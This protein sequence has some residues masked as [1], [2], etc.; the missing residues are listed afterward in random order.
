MKKYNW[1]ILGCGKIAKKFASDLKLLSNANLYA[2]ASRSLQKAQ[3]FA[4]TFGFEK[5]YGGYEEMLK[6]TELDVVYIA[7]PHTFHA[8]HSLLSINHGKAVLCEKA[9]AI[10]EKEVIQM[11]TASN[12][13]KIFLMEA[14]WTRF[15]PS[16]QKV[17]EIIKTNELGDLK[18]I[19][20]DF[21]F[22][23]PFN[24]ESR[25]YNLDLGGGSLLDIGIYPVFTALMA[26]GVPDE[27]A[28]KAKLSKTGSDEYLEMVFSYTNG[29]KAYL[30]SGFTCDSFNETIFHFE[31]GVI[32]ISRELNAPIT[33]KKNKEVNELIVDDGVGFGYQFE[34]NHVMDCLDKGLT[35]S[36][37]LPHTFSLQLMQILD[38]VRSKIGVVY[39]NHD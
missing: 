18:I 24:T 33:I 28:A 9:F 36:P 12:D 14:F 29:A 8:E 25:L 15:I 19:Q 23:A 10:N 35:E 4:T 34:A 39:P 6:D 2:T 30:K 20:S 11:I 1:G 13:H 22:F 21:M 7:T 16:F 27:I 37:I 38:K 17:L 5:A 32:K 26:L 3:D 31:N